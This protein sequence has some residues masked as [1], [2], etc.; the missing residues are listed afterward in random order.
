MTQE[1]LYRPKVRAAFKEV[2][3]ETVAKPVRVNASRNACS[4]RQLLQ[5]TTHS[6]RLQRGT[7]TP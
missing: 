7:S 1:L 2:R 3:G 4:G 6:I 5:T